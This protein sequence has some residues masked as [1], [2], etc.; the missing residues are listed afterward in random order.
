MSIELCDCLDY[1]EAD[2]PHTTTPN[3]QCRMKEK[4]MRKVYKYQLDVVREQSL[5]MP[6]G[7]KIIALHMQ[8]DVPT[9][10]AVVDVDTDMRQAREFAIVGTGHAPVEDNYKFIGTVCEFNRPLVWH[11]FEVMPVIE[12]KPKTLFGGRP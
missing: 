4:T 11:V 5:V 12:D 7:A 3:K 2:D 9:L 6:Y 10:W 8:N 1:C